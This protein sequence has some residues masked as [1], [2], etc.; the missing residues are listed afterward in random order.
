MTAERMRK[1]KSQNITPKA[2]DKHSK[3]D[4]TLY[5]VQKKVPGKTRCS[6]F[7]FQTAEEAES[8][9]K[10]YSGTNPP[11]SAEYADVQAHRYLTRTAN[12][13]HELE[14]S[15]KGLPAGE[16]YQ[17]Y[18]AGI[19]GRKTG[20]YYSLYFQS[21]TDAGRLCAEIGVSLRPKPVNVYRETAEKYLRETKDT[22][23]ELGI[24]DTDSGQDIDLSAN[25]LKTVYLVQLTA[26][27]RT[28]RY[29]FIF[30]SKEEADDFY[31]KHPN[32]YPPY[33]TVLLESKVQGALKSTA[34]KIQELEAKKLNEPSLN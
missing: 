13:L 25:R 28:D 18:L 30:Q 9:H 27:N 23:A 6:V 33:S 10:K 1:M 26:P 21:R 34:E 11:V 4:C 7:Y 12:K 5:S 20:R 31:G 24:A 15:E 17:I 22:L 8:F 14:A 2:D 29:S 16:K 32:S 3:I 19:R